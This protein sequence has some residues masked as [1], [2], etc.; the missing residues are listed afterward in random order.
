MDAG[1][2]SGPGGV[3]ANPLKRRDVGVGGEEQS[4]G[5]DPAGTCRTLAGVLSCEGHFVC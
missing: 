3:S 5:R 1:R 4:V 2:G